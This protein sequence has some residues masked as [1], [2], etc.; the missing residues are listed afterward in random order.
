MTATSSLILMH[1]ITLVSLNIERHKHVER[2]ASFL[3]ACKP[4]VVCLQEILEEHIQEFAGAMGATEHA[5]A[6]MW[7]RPQ[8]SSSVMG[9]TILSRLPIKRKTAEYY[10]GDPAHLPESFLG[11]AETYNNMNR[12]LLISDVEKEGKPFRSAA[13]GLQLTAEGRQSRLPREHKGAFHKK[14]GAEGGLVFSGDFN[15]PRG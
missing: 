9:V 10:V 13:T 5:F 7:L 4:D 6:P 1:T 15:T 8:E 11:R 12:A 3:S 14:L 2:V